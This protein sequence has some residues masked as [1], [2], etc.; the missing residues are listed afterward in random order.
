MFVI[1]LPLPQVEVAV[2]P[3]MFEIVTQGI[4]VEPRL[5]IRS[6]GTVVVEALATWSKQRRERMTPNMMYFFMQC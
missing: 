1:P 3:E 2:S 4:P 5:T 6:P